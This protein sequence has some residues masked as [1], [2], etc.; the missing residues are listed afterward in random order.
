MT[1]YQES[2]A[3]SRQDKDTSA[4]GCLIPLIAATVLLAIAI[5]LIS[6]LVLGGD[7]PPRV[8]SDEVEIVAEADSQPTSSASSPSASSPGASAVSPRESVSSQALLE[9]VESG[10]WIEF[11]QPE[12]I[13]LKSQ[14]QTTR[15]FRRRDEH[16]AVTIHS[17][18]N[19]A[20]LQ[21]I[22]D[23]TDPPAQA[24]AFDSMVVVVAPLTDG[25]RSKVEPLADRLRK[26]RDLLDESES[27]E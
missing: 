24:I 21:N 12:V 25:A 5:T 3:A 7:E 17:A 2:D 26:F 10:G 6:W 8:E 18:K 13:D 27:A 1:S 22:L 19:Y 16:I 20:G 23:E 14:Q 15:K 11:G 9:V 4:L